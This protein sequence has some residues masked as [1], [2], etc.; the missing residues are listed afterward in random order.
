MKPVVDDESARDPDCVVP[1]CVSQLE[2][3]GD[4]FL[5]RDG[6]SLRMNRGC[7]SIAPDIGC[8][9]SEISV[10]GLTRSDLRREI[11]DHAGISFSQMEVCIFMDHSMAYILL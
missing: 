2:V 7:S 1:V 6:P 9:Q 4:I 5:S 10:A 3:V 8:I 11:I